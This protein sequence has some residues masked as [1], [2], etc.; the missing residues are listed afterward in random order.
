MT[1]DIKDKYHSVNVV[2]YAYIRVGTYKM[3]AQKLAP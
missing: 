3:P 2:F 1:D